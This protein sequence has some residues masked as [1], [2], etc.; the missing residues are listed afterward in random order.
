MARAIWSGSLSF[1]LVN[2]P[3]EIHTAVR[4]HR[5]RFRMLH[6]KDRSPINFERVCQKE[7]KT[8]A[9]EDLVKGYE[10][11]KGRFVV[12]TKEDFEAAAL[13]KTRRIDVLDFVEADAIDDRYFDTPYYLTA[14][15]GGEVAYALLREAMNDA[16]R[17][18]I[19]KFILRET[20]HLAA[21][22][23]IGDALVLST[24][25]FA[26]ELVDTS[27]LT[28]P[29]G[30]HVKAGELNLA[31]TLIEN[32]AS[33]WNPDKYKDDYQINLMRVIKA[34]MKG[35]EPKLVVDERD[36]DSNVI[37]LMER[38][39]Q[40]LDRSDG[41]RRAGQTGSGEGARKG[42]RGTTR[43][44]ASASRKISARPRKQR[45]RKAHAAA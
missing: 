43:R 31:K 34:K 25:R 28:F 11:E 24:L 9:W 2:I 17:I 37:D 13:E 27:S 26:D 4:D 29:S 39:R 12:L 42:G 1:G 44:A 41:R 19:A 3:V 32:L 22:E 16:G 35:R 18:G 38:L 20:Q 21:V 45:R 8:V 15:K 14:K 30:K 40:S 36:R 33:E 6:G 23:G 5:P 7:R 10:Y